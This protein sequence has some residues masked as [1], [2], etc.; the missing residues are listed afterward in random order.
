MTGII[1]SSFSRTVLIILKHTGGHLFTGKN[2]QCY[3][4]L[5]LILIWK[6]YGEDKPCSMKSTVTPE[7]NSQE[8]GH[9]WETI[10][11]QVLKLN[12]VPLTI[13]VTL[14]SHNLH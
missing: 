11:Y 6:D 5:V 12:S 9:T 8:S 3:C 1:H 2:S 10:S 14:D 7:T 4:Q 13:L